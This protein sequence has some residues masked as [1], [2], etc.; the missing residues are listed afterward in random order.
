MLRNS[1]GAARRA[2]PLVG[3]LLLA[4]LGCNRG[5]WTPDEPREAE[6]AREMALTPSVIPTLDGQRFIEKPPLYY[7]VV[8]GLFRAVGSP[9]VVVARA[10]SVVSGLATLLLLYLWISATQSSKAAWVA[11]IMLATSV[12]FVIS[13]HWVLIDPLL[14]LM[15]TI[16][17]WSAWQIIYRP[18]PSNRLLLLFYLALVSAL[19]IKGPIGPVLIGGGLFAYAALDHHVHW[20]RWRPILGTA[21]LVAAAMILAGVIYL[22]GGS[23][24]LWEWAYVN[25]VGRMLNPSATGH[26]EPLLYYAWTLPYAVLPWVPALLQALRP[27]QWKRSLKAWWGTASPRRQGQAHADAHGLQT[28]APD[29]ARYGAIMAGAMVVLLSTSA[30]KRETYLLPVLPLLFLWLGIRSYQWWLGFQTGPS[31]PYPPLWWAQVALLCLYASSAPLAAAVWTHSVSIPIGLGLTLALIAGG[32]LIYFSAVAAPRTAAICALLTAWAG[33]TIWLA[34]AGPMLDRTKNMAPFMRALE[35]QLPQ[36]QPVFAVHVDETLEAEVPFYTGR[37]LIP[38][39]LQ[40]SVTDR[41]GTSWAS[42]DAALPEWVLVQNGD[43]GCD[44][45]PR[46]YVLTM[47]RSFGGRTLALCRR[48][49]GS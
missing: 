14:M 2:W 47:R 23:A 16:A 9:S 36:A 42:G 40:S 43:S 24:A 46:D 17:A 33:T 6:I 41:P 7:W 4:V 25:Q 31:R 45:L 21:V 1:R 35:R 5:L 28:T 39:D 11:V 26:R 34:L 27:R 37:T 19:W 32:T 48:A 12:Q 22:R 10:V 29:P 44:P 18:A 15:T 20:R 3:L 8:A 38:L 13:T 30:T 49:R